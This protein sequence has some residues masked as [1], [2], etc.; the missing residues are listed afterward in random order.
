MFV[1]YNFV[2]T[3]CYTAINLLYSSLSAMMT[4]ISSE[5]D[6]LSI[7]RMGVSPF[8]RILEVTCTM[9]VVKIFGND[10]WAWAKTMALWAGIALV[11]L[12]ICFLCC[13]EKV[14]IEAK[15]NM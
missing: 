12:I 15:S 14:Q 11:L 1:T 5:R 9:P 2:T 10:Q 8:G 3:V 7:V 13:E 4:R 6:M